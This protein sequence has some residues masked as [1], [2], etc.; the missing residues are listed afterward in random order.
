MPP[1]RTATTGGR[2]PVPPQLK[3]WA[4]EAGLKEDVELLQERGLTACERHVLVK[5]FKGLGEN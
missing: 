2:A 5:V 3:L 1:R 4:L